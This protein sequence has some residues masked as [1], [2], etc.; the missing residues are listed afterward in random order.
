V[1]ANVAAVDDLTSRVLSAPE[2]ERLARYRS[3]AAAARYVITRSLVRLV[4]SDR[5]SLPAS[6]VRIGQTDF[7]KPVVADA[8]HFNV[9]H[10]G[11]LVLLALSADRAVGIDVERRRGVERVSALVER[12]LTSDEQRAVAERVDA[13]ADLSDAFLRVWSLKEARLKALGVGIANAAHADIDAVSVLPLDG[14]LE[15]LD[16]GTESEGYIGAVAFA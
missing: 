2:R 6:E 15:R 1:G 7:G 3:A 16:P 8:L 11:D 13:G 12:W 4:L 10:S 14:L 5:L 9:S